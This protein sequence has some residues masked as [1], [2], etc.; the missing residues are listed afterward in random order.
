GS[1]AGS[2]EGSRFEAAGRYIR[3]GRVAIRVWDRAGLGARRDIAGPLTTIM[4]VLPCADGIVFGA[5]DPAFGVLD[6]KGNP[7]TWQD[8]VQADMR[9]KL[10]QNFTVSADGR[11]IRFG[12]KEGGGEPVL[13]DLAAGTL[14]DAPNPL[15][16]LSPSSTQGLPITDWLNGAQP[17]F[18]GATLKLEPY[19]L[20]RAL[21]V[22][23][24]RERFVLGTEY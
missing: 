2:A 12:F 18:G 10:L 21:A 19:E 11:R 14:T 4:H 5:A 7:R 22:A 17:K 1:V 6:S 3:E 23:P 9:G 20:A 16:E 13:F 24:N 8:S 15:A